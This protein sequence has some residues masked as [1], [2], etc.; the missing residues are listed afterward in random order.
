MADKIFPTDFT[1]LTAFNSQD[2][3]P[4][5]GLNSADMEYAETGKII[6]D[7][8][9]I[10]VTLPNGNVPKSNGTKLIDSGI[11]AVDLATITDQTA[12][13]IPIF[14]GSTTELTPSN[15]FIKA[16]TS[17]NNTYAKGLFP[18]NVSINGNILV[19]RVGFDN[20]TRGLSVALYNNGTTQK[21]ALHTS[22]SGN[23]SSTPTWIATED[24]VET[25]VGANT[26][27]FVRVYYATA[28]GLPT[29][30]EESDVL[31]A[32]EDGVLL[33]DTDQTPPLASLVFVKD[34][35]YPTKNG[36]YTVTD[37]G[38]ESSPWILTLLSEPLVVNVANNG[39]GTQGGTW[40]QTNGF[41]DDTYSYAKF[42]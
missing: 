10:G 20:G 15:L 21:A 34:E 35:T 23:V 9:G 8:T 28:A 40:I 38:S 17:W 36:V 22:T 39:Y 16:L 2:K 1:E 25:Y 11:P 13:E 27:S 24:Y 6:E 7:A 29:Y 41:D 3:I 4:I 37:A 14:N 19:G 42:S 31:T 30:T 32:A 33:I 26:A 12:N 5:Q 18:S